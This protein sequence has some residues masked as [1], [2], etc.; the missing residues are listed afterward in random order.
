MPVEIP[1]AEKPCRLWRS[2]DREPRTAN[3]KLAEPAGPVC[4][5]ISVL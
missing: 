1:L 3:R 2:G 5:L 4:H